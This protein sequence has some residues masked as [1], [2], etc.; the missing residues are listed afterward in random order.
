MS[1]LAGAPRPQQRSAILAALRQAPAART[2]LAQS[3]GLSPSLIGRVVTGLVEDG[4]VVEAGSITVPVGR[5]RTEL[6]LNVGAGALGAVICQDAH[7]VTGLFDL[8]GRQ[9]FEARTPIGALPVDPVSFAAAIRSAHA[10]SPVADCPLIAAGVSVPGVV[11]AAT[12]AVSAAPDL[13][14]AGP[15]ALGEIVAQRLGALVTVDNDVNLMVLAEIAHGAAQ[16]LRDVVLVYLGGRGVGAGIVAHG[17]LVVG[18]HGAAGEIGLAPLGVPSGRR[19]MAGLE[20]RC[21]VEAIAAALAEAGLD[22]G[23]DPMTALANH[24][25]AGVPQA[26]RLRRATLDAVAYALTWVALMGDP[27]VIL[28][29]GAIRHLLACDLDTLTHRLAGRVP[30][31]PE[32]SCAALDSG[33]ILTAAQE[34][35]WTT[36]LA[37]GIDRPSAPARPAGRGA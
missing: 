14:W 10:A 8:A 27:Q 2:E 6:A 24:A 23:P 37:R 34:R 18:C 7:L 12:G 21:S 16:G 1:E 29:G 19:A 31:L 5:P 33:A 28:I 4:Y 13:G 30:M 15:V 3:L 17:Q 36:W 20:Q 9:V 26:R 35:C 25:R 11:D 32:I 22:T